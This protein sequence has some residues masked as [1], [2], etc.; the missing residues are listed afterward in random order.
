[1]IPDKI[2]KVDTKTKEWKMWREKGAYPS[3]PVFVNRPGGVD[4]QDGV[5]LSILIYSD[6]KRPIELICLGNVSNPDFSIL[7]TSFEAIYR[8]KGLDRNW[9][10][11]NKRFI[12]ALRISSLLSTNGLFE[13]NS[14]TTS[15]STSN[16]LIEIVFH[17]YS[18]DLNIIKACKIFFVNVCFRCTVEFVLRIKTELRNR[19]VKIN[20]RR[21][22]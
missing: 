7:N 9:T 21:H 12:A 22:F 5:I 17:Y 20:M 13:K 10:S 16:K 15:W 14:T 19:C 4:E 1:M 18:K 3:E 11:G 2:L 8:S 6:G